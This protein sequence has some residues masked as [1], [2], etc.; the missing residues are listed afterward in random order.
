MASHDVLHVWHGY[1][2]LSI[3]QWPSIALLLLVI[4]SFTLAAP[5]TECVQR[6]CPCE[7]APAS[8]APARQ[9]GGDKGEG[10]GDQQQQGLC[11]AGAAPAAGSQPGGD[12]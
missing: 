12:A 4:W 2:A 7:E 10:E 6:L 1:G 8:G 11:G 9:Q 3:P 5:S